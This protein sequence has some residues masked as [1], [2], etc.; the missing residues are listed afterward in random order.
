M[1]LLAFVAARGGD[2]HGR[3]VRIL[4]KT[5]VALLIFAQPSGARAEGPTPEVVVSRPLA[6]TIPHWEEYTG[7]F[8]ALKQVE[9][10]ARVSGTLEKINFT[11]GQFVK[12]DD[13]LFVIDQ[14]PYQ[15][16]VD[17]ARA[18]LART[19]AQAAMSTRDY[20]RAQEMTQGRTITARDVDQRKASSEI[21]KAQVA[22]AEAAL[23]NAELNLEWTQVRAP[24]SGRVSDRRVDPGNLVQGGQAGAT[25]LTTIVTLD[26]IHFVFDA[27][28]ADYIRYAR[29]SENQKKPEREFNNR[30]SVRLADETEWTRSGVM[31]FLDNQINRRSGTIRGRA[32]FDNKDYFLTPGAFGRLRL[33][34]G[35]VAA[36][37]I[38][39][40]AIVSDQTSKTVLV[41]TDDNKVIAKSVALGPIHRGLRVIQSGLDAK[42]RIVIGGLAN[43]MVRPGA[44]VRPKEGEIKEAPVA[45][46]G[47]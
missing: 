24:I 18:E 45:L 34:S 23:R 30:V 16:A 44:S 32:V 8:E 29:G 33:F 7:R 5:F 2:G 15:I 41:V 35:D 12:A 1:T 39:D 19:Q 6:K 3:V 13:V 31:D 40:A 47:R 22:S 46:G 43:P 20:A 26:P 42:D 28:E 10:R 9:V 11:D 36:L 37:L 27:S 21:A 25:L 14:R 38:P 4:H 17:S